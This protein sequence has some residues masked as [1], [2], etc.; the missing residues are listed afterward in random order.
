MK[1]NNRRKAST[2]ER[3]ALTGVI[4]VT[5]LA[6]LGFGASASFT[7]TA[8]EE[9]SVDA[10][11]TGLVIGDGGVNSSNR[12]IVDAVD[13]APGDSI[14]RSFDLISSGSIDLQALQ[15]EISAIDSSD[16]DTDTVNGLQFT[17]QECS[18]PWTE[19]QVGANPDVY[20]YSCGGSVT[21]HIDSVP[22]IQGPSALDLVAPIETAGTT[23]HLVST[24]DLPT[25][26]DNRFQ[27]DST[28]LEYE[29]TAIQRD[30]TN[31]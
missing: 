4:G 2:T 16:L 30:G 13:V 20:T 28:L 11:T 6:L 9:Q 18:I 1:K 26:A 12:L 10:G 21:T 22:V 15:M 25:T 14:Q 19:T 7:E 24:L 29:F 8:D 3:L 17:L 5:T 23:A 27:G 31:R